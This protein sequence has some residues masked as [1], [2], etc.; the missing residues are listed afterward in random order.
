MVKEIQALYQ[1]CTSANPKSVAP[2]NSKLVGVLKNKMTLNLENQNDVT[3]FLINLCALMD[4]EGN[5]AGNNKT[6]RLPLESLFRTSLTRKEICAGCTSEI[7]ETS[8]HM[9]ID[10]ICRNVVQNKT[11]ISL[12]DFVQKNFDMKSATECSTCA[13]YSTRS[14]TKT[15]NNGSKYALLNIERNVFSKQKKTF[16]KCNNRIEVRST[17]QI[18]LS[19]EDKKRTTQFKLIGGAAHQG[20]GNSGH[21]WAIVK[22]E[23]GWHRFDDHI[24]EQITEAEALRELSGSGVLLLLEKVE[25]P[26]NGKLYTPIVTKNEK[27]QQPRDK[28]QK[29]Q[30]EKKSIGNTDELEFF[31]IRRGRGWFNFYIR[32]HDQTYDPY[33]KAVYTRKKGSNGTSN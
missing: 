19:N 31:R 18:G 7:T 16:T 4:N 17:M 10:L 27:P 29:S 6:T 2:S 8:N 23:N 1:K 28:E 25:A 12:E 3:E 14:I 33:K 24:T 9:H 21:Y 20:S 13:Q 5:R 26:L 30:K 11:A 15:V 32:K 22:H